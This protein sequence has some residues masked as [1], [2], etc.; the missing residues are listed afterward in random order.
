MA[1]ITAVPS[2]S[3]TTP[4]SNGSPWLDGR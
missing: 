4:I 2:S 3:V 1:W